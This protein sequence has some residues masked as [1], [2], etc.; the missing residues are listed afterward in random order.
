MQVQFTDNQIFDIHYAVSQNLPK[1]ACCL[2][3]SC[4]RNDIYPTIHFIYRSVFELIGCSPCQKKNK[5]KK[6][7]KKEPRNICILV[8]GNVA[9]F[10]I[11]EE[12]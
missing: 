11:L 1:L 2:H 12:K 9:R 5:N 10:N 4:E 7:I 3:V 6:T 8:K